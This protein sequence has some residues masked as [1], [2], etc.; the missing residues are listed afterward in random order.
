MV[1][2]WYRAN[3]EAAPQVSPSVSAMLAPPELFRRR[4]GGEWG[5]NGGCAAF[6]LQVR[7]CSAHHAPMTPS[8]EA[9][10]FDPSRTY[11][12]VV[13]GGGNAGLCAAITARQAGASVLLLEQAPRDQRGG[14]S[15]HVR[16]LRVM[17][18]APSEFLHERYLEDEYWDD[19]A[20]VTGGNTDEKLARITINES[21]GV[22]HWMEQCG[23]RFQRSHGGTKNPS[24]KTAFLLGGGKAL[25]NAYYLTA[26]RLG[27][28][29]LYNAEVRS[30]RLDDGFA[31]ETTVVSHGVPTKLRAKAVV[32]ASGG[33]Q[34]NIGWLRNYWGEAADRFLVRGT[35]YAKGEMLKDLLDQDVAPIGNP[36]RC[37]F[38][39]VDARAPK[40][41]GGIVTR[42]DCTP[43]SIVVDLNSRRFYD[44]GADIGPKRYAIWGRL[45]AQCPCQIAYAIFDSK[46]EQYFRPSI[47][48]PIRAPTIAE[49]AGKLAL[50]P[51]ALVATVHAFNNAVRSGPPD[52]NGPGHWQTE[53]IAPPK[54]RWALPIDA[55]PFNSYPLRPGIT[56][57]YLGVKVDET[58]RVLMTDGRPS[59]N[60]FAAGLIMASNVLGQGYLAGMGMTIGTV[61][62]RIA[63]REAAKCANR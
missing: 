36:A 34:A 14:N 21:S 22:T 12:V 33:C 48:P 35:A 41:D 17:H 11:D 8:A 10:M 5:S 25:L 30:L 20:R 39:A 47:Y 19:L 1:S 49:L 52:G 18:D 2:G 31:R 38:V 44:E 45:V 4:C 7:S 60:V 62:G 63:G 9:G 50:D 54:T 32:V 59:A 23:G 51:P 16:N 6:S 24:R 28:D 42:L 56:F 61:F 55:P 37:H 3:T 27:V 43:F 29:I 53:G 15:R 46:A 40:F 57:C 58:A 13:V 26:Q